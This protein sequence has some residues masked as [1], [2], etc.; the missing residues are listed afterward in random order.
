MAYFF[1]PKPAA[2]AGELMASDS[3]KAERVIDNLEAAIQ[4]YLAE[5]SGS[6]VDAYTQAQQQWSAGFTEMRTALFAAQQAFNEVGL[7]YVGT[8]LAGAAA[9][10]GNIH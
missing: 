8:D 7:N 5:V 1:D 9:F 4:G 6:S 2:D 10:E 3:A